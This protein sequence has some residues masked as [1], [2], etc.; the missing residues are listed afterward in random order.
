MDRLKGYPQE[1]QHSAALTA[2]K[3][4][5]VPPAMRSVFYPREGWKPEGPRQSLSVARFTTARSGGRALNQA[6]KTDRS[7]SSAS[8]ADAADAR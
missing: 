1:R 5:R 2:E 6:D 7:A 3:R 4:D 8:A